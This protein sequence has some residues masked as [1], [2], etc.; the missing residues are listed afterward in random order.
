MTVGDRQRRGDKKCRAD[1]P[2]AKFDASDAGQAMLVRRSSCG[3][4]SDCHVPVLKDEA[5]SI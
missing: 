5:K 1:M 2:F 4:S 3:C